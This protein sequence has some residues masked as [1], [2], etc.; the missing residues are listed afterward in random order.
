MKQQNGDVRPRATADRPRP[1]S[2]HL[3][4]FRRGILVSLAALVAGSVVAFLAYDLILPWL[5][6]PLGPVPNGPMGNQLYLNSLAEGFLVKLRISVTTGFALSFPVHLYTLVAFIWPALARRERRVVLAVLLPGSVLAIGGAYYGYSLLAPL[7]VDFL[8]SDPFVPDQV[9]LLL[10]YGSGLHDV[11]WMIA[12]S[13]IALQL[14]VVLVTLLALK[15]LRR[16]TVWRASRFVILGI[17]IVS[18]I[19]T[20]ADLV[21]QVALA[22]PL[23]ALYFGAL[24]LA[25]VFRLGED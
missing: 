24:L 2:E 3:G 20:P 13:A 1:L 14:P 21:S 17:L 8:T 23:T 7:A 9:G 25:V 6:A 16:R 10:N 12:G 15:V 5:T 4:E 19:L 18:A 22:A 11:V